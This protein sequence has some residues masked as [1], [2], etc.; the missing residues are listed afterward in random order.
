MIALLVQS[1]PSPMAL[2]N[3]G[4]ADESH[5]V[6]NSHVRDGVG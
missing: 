4:S 1:F 3:S 2:L 6:A 5:K